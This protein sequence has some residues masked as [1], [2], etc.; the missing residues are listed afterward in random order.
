MENMRRSIPQCGQR[1]SKSAPCSPAKP[2]KKPP[3]L[4]AR[5][6][7][8]HI[9]HKVPLGD[10]PYVRAKHV[11]L[12]EKDPDRAIAL[13]WAAINSN[14]RVDSALKDMA[15]VM[16]QQNRPEEAIEAIKS[17]RNRCSDQ[18][19]ESLDNVLLDLFKRCGRLDDQI[20]LLKHK[21]NL[22]HQGMAFNGKRTKTARSQG[23]KFQVSIEQETTRLLGN[24]GWAYMQ[25]NNYVAAEAVYR[26]ALSIEPDNNK[27]CNLGICLMKQGRIVEAKAMLRCVKPASSEG[28]W[29]LDSHLKSY[30]RAQEMLKE[31]EL[32]SQ[33]N[34]N[35]NPESELAI[36]ALQSSLWWQPQPCPARHQF[37]NRNQQTK[38]LVSDSLGAGHTTTFLATA[39]FGPLQHKSQH[40]VLAPPPPKA[41]NSHFSMFSN[42]FWEENGGDGV[43]EAF[44]DENINSNINIPGRL[45]PLGANGS[46]MQRH[47]G[48]LKQKLDQVVFN[49]T[50]KAAF[51]PLT[52]NNIMN[53][54]HLLNSAAPPFFVRNNNNKQGTEDRMPLTL[55]MTNNPNIVM[56]FAAVNPVLGDNGRNAAKFREPINENHPPPRRSLS[57]GCVDNGGNFDSLH[58]TDEH[59]FHLQ[60]NKPLTK[61]NS[62]SLPLQDMA[63]PWPDSQEFEDAILAAL[64]DSN[65][66]S[67]EDK[68]R[69]R[70]R[71]FQELTASPKVGKGLA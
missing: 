23:K 60:N 46:M 69:K 33:S 26:K 24:L 49:G 1:I 59:H 34:S 29:G 38:S 64:C 65:P 3:S 36:A 41:P 54:D 43:G 71:V 20:G 37:P 68:V 63:D 35:E 14:D 45:P 5:A 15:I 19:Q 17:L 28:P 52:S 55:D 7:S 58:S 39:G 51:P 62:I 61:A 9:I 31:L 25:Q 13:F 70:L 67:H 6:D 47:T 44:A 30:E 56:P 66:T 21:L 57:F 50:A 8:F 18:A 48:A 2:S 16:K 10:T 4:P 40:P 42:G 22:I 12:V 27:M 11:Q 53:K 32:Q